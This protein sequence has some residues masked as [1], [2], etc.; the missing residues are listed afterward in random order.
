[1]DGSIINNTK[2]HTDYD[3]WLRAIQHTNC[4]YIK[5]ICFYY[6]TGHGDGQLY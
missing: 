5:D 3:Y 1:M 6:D 4:V 2:I